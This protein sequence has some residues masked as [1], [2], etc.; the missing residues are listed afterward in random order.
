MRLAALLFVAALATC[1]V[2]AQAA[3]KITI[4]TATLSPQEIQDRDVVR[5]VLA[6]GSLKAAAAYEQDLLTVINHA[7]TTYPMIER[8]DRMTIL[9]SNSEQEAMS[10]ALMFGLL[11]SVKDSAKIT[12]AGTY[13]TYGMAILFL[14]S[15]ANE[16]H[17][18]R[19][20]IAYLDKGLAFQPDN[21]MLITEKGAALVALQRFSD[22][23]ELYEAAEKIDFVTK[24]LDPGGEARLLRA[25]GFA[26]IELNRLDEAKA[27]YEEALKLDPDHAGA[28]AE[29]DYIGKLRAGDQ[30]QKFVLVPGDKAKSEGANGKAKDGDAAAP[31]P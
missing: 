22:A 24:N 11:G 3:S 17:D 18:P 9:R 14:G 19:R 15:I 7:P 4:A 21:L 20:A 5:K 26:L 10:A 30:Q 31:K 2:S 1:P 29:L 8:T 16:G 27:S 12:V 23:L 6:A 13:N 28:K 25:K